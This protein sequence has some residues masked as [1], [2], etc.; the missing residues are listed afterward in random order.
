MSSR[1]F[2]ARARSSDADFNV[3]R[4]SPSRTKIPERDHFNLKLSRAKLGGLAAAI[5]LGSLAAA[6]AHALPIV[7]PANDYLASY[8]GNR[9][10]G[11]LDILSA[12]VV[13]DGVAFHVG[14]TMNGAIGT[15]SPSLYVLG[16]NRGSG[17]APF[18]TVGEGNVLFDTVVTFTGAGVKGGRNTVAAVNLTAAQLA[19]IVLTIAGAAYTMDIPLTALPGS[20]GLTPD[21][22]RFNLWTRD[23]SQTGNAALADFAPNN[24][25]FI[26]DV[27]EP[28]STA[29]MGTGLL[30][31]GYLRRRRGA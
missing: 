13:F 31:L 29:L 4:E 24:A 22:Y 26:A 27:P 11:D 7:D 18:A 14:G 17:T 8:T 21:Q 25:T 23:Q 15:T 5:V 1:T 2:R 16:I 3:R 9:T 30:G 12:S 28:V 19:Q 20:A 6:P 10:N